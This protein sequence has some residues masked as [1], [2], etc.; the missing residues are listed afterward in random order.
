MQNQV[1]HHHHD[2][3]GRVYCNEDLDR[4]NGV[5]EG[6]LTRPARRICR[7][8]QVFWTLLPPPGERSTHPTDNRGQDL[9]PY[10]RPGCLACLGARPGVHQTGTFS[11][12]GIPVPRIRLYI[13]MCRNMRP[14]TPHK[15]IPDNATALS[16]DIHIMSCGLT[17][18]TWRGFFLES[19][20]SWIRGRKPASYMDVIDHMSTNAYCGIV[21]GDVRGRRHAPLSPVRGRHVAYTKT[22]ESRKESPVIYKRYLPVRRPSVAG[23]VET[24]GVG[25]DQGAKSG[26]WRSEK[27]VLC[28]VMRHTPCSD[29]I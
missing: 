28:I 6:G 8:N 9:K 10:L 17:C 15:H 26:C 23:V 29:R 11:S 2:C 7:K 14:G 16:L 21:S 20:G 25:A 1:C 12:S 18:L 27:H 24:V 22:P 4:L 19:G 5:P 3:F 13:M